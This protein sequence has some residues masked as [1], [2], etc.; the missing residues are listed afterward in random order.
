[1]A[2][3]SG[4]AS[5]AGSTPCTQTVIHEMKKEFQVV[6]VSVRLQRSATVTERL[7]SSSITYVASLTAMKRGLWQESAVSV[8][9]ELGLDGA[10]IRGRRG[11]EGRPHRRASIASCSI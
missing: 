5:T 7:S 10:G 4:E 6:C 3:R 11:G 2:G 8:A 1:V 9:H